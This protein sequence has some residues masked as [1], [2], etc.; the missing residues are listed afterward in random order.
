MQLPLPASKPAPACSPL[1]CETH[2]SLSMG[3]AICFCNPQ[4]SGRWHCP[5]MQMG[6]EMQDG[7][8]ESEGAKAGFPSLGV[9]LRS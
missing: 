6:M 8:R 3:F 4:E 2:L 9:H 7:A 5:L 1:L